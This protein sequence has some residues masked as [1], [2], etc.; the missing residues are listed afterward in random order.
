MK[1]KG[2]FILALTALA[3]ASEVHA[4][5]IDTYSY[6]A[7]TSTGGAIV[8]GSSNTFNLYLKESYATSGGSSFIAADGGLYSASVA[9][10]EQTGGTGATITAEAVNNL[11]EPNGFTGN[12]NAHALNGSPAGAYLQGVQNNSASSGNVYTSTS[13]SGGVTTNLFLIG[14]VTMTVASNANATFNID[15]FKN[16]PTG[17][18]LSQAGQTGTTITTSDDVDLDA[19]GTFTGY[20]ITG[21]NATVNH[22]VLSAPEPGSFGLILLGSLGVLARRRRKA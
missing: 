4:A 9:L 17:D 13:N 2:L 7:T 8:Y 15:S 11:T 3:G 20:T 5:S 16:T 14:T 6:V 10:V 21:A 12:N 19:G 22:L 1:K 18:G